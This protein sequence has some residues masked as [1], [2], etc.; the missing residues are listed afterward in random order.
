MT[1][2]VL[3]FSSQIDDIVF[4]L[5]QL[6]SY[7]TLWFQ[8]SQQ[9]WSIDWDHAI[10]LWK[11]NGNWQAPGLQMNRDQDRAPWCPLRPSRDEQPIH[12]DET[13]QHFLKSRNCEAQVSLPLTY[14]YVIY[15]TLPNRIKLKTCSLISTT[16]YESKLH[17]MTRLL[18]PLLCIVLPPLR[19]FSFKA[20]NLCCILLRFPLHCTQLLFLII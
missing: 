19:Q 15:N 4:T 13:E 14:E 18:F 1:N 7:I 5:V 2:I 11:K 8:G 16:V 20:C 6:L 3:Y 10:E 12:R 9:G 17:Q